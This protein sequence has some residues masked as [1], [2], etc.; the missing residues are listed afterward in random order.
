MTRIIILGGRSFIAK[1]MAAACDKRKLPYRS[2]FHD[3]P[4][5][6][7]TVTDA[8]FN[9]AISPDYRRLPYRA[10]MDCDL[11]AAQAVARSGAWF[12]MLSTRRV[13][14]PEA[15][16]NAREYIGADGDE[17]VYGRNKALTEKAVR[18]ILPGQAGIFRLS[19]A[20]GYEYDRDGQRRSF[21]GLLLTSLKQSN[22]ILFDMSRDT[23]RD[24]IPVETCVEML[25]DRALS[26]TAGTYNLGSGLPLSCGTL[27]H[28][29]CEGYGGGELICDPEIVHDEFY[30]NMDKWRETFASSVDEATLRDYC[31]GLGRRLKCEKS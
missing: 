15:R 6:G 21:L 22:R 16:W 4:L 5:E 17:T 13:Y 24:F 23:R 25:L 9:F 30:L 11:A 18:D 8:I 7:L 14:G 12:G 19:N 26:R 20:F 28:W 3:A 1:A 29:I 2:L 31:V 27:A 10:G